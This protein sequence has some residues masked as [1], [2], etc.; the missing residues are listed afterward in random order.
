MTA[1]GYN[2]SLLAILSVGRKMLVEYLVVI[3]IVAGSLVLQCA[4]QDVPSFDPEHPLPT[5]V[6]HKL[7]QHQD[8]TGP[9]DRPELLTDHTHFVS[10]PN[11]HQH[12]HTGFFHNVPPAPEPSV[13]SYIATLSYGEGYPTV[14]Y[15][16]S[17]TEHKPTTPYT[18]GPSGHV[19]TVSFLKDPRRSQRNEVID[20]IIGTILLMPWMKEPNSRAFSMP[21]PIP[22]LFA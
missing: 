8:H 3:S 14:I 7:G 10:G 17:H 18:Y 2:N 5:V 22:L 16:C 4:A 1:M 13:N 15:H 11:V 12:H 6:P 21:A 9:L 20:R 19:C